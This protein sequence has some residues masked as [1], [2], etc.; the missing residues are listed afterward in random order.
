MDKLGLKGKILFVL[1]AV[2]L[3]ISAILFN[4]EQ[5]ILAVISFIVAVIFALLLV[6]VHKKEF[7]SNE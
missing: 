2:F 5:M 7:K 6:M 1:F 4:F 3:I